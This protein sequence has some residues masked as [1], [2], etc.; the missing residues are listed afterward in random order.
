MPTTVPHM[1]LVFV[2]EMNNDTNSIEGIGVIRNYINRKYNTCI[3]KS[4]HNYNRYIYNSAYRKNIDEIEN[5][6]VIEILELMLFYGSR[7]YK[8]GQGITTINWNR[9][10]DKA[11]FVMKHFFHSL[12]DDDD[13]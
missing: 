11:K 3:Y 4:D 10:E 12:F 1:A 5:K 6:K 9:F 8:R 2:I 13:L 7:H